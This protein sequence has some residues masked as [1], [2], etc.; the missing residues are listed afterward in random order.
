MIYDV[1][2]I[3]FGPSNIALAIA[4]E[5]NGN[6]ETVK[7]IEK[8]TGPS[9]HENM[10]LNGADI[11]NNPLR[12]LITPV[13]PRSQYTFV[14]YLHVNKK[15][16]LFLNTGLH[17]PLRKD[18][19]DY[20]CWVANQF[21]NVDYGIEASH[22]HIEELDEGSIWVV[23][24]SSGH[25]Y[26]GRRLVMGTGR[27][28]NIPNISGLADTTKAIHLTNYL[29]AISELDKSSKIAVLGASQSA[30]E[31]LLDLLNKGFDNIVSIHRS[32]S[33][34]QKDT[35]PFSDEVYFP[36]FINYYHALSVEKRE[37]LDHQVR[38]TNYSSADID[39]INNLNIRMYEDNLDGN[40][41]LKIIRNHEIIEAKE[42]DSL[43]LHIR[44]LYTSVDEELDV[45]LLILA[46]G[47]LDI[48][49]NGRAGLP[50]IIE[51]LA[52]LF[53]WT[54]HYLEVKR[55][56]RVRYSN[57]HIYPDLYLN[58]LCESSHGLG[59]AGSFSLVSLRAQEIARSI[60]KRMS[61]FPESVTEHYQSIA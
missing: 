22:I 40:C 48:G 35:S 20:V 33:Y 46:T 31:I 30:V 6:N 53:S 52:P 19:Y 27:K 42:N 45:D 28:L 58:G 16:F 37:R 13:N 43:N 3:G 23:E 5:E 32:F 12:D 50:K 26:R 15:F 39:V 11:Q 24:T 47:F 54:D 1:L 29:P 60:S 36:E 55:D 44:D 18:F 9:W 57:K 8:N 17:Y 14:N 59:D 4:L 34:R 7:F 2:G 38:Q 10:L 21:N 25:V 41:R 49:R 61:D 51:P 56:Y